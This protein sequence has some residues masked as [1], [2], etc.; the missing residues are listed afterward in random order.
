VTI[1]CDVPNVIIFGPKDPL[2]HAVSMTWNDGSECTTSGNFR[3]SEF[4][5]NEQFCFRQK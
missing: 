3:S 2:D 5:Q 1:I 4:V